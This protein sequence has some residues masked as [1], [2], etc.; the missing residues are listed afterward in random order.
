M[1]ITV[2]L[3]QFR[4]LVVAAL[5]AFVGTGCDQ[6]SAQ[7]ARSEES[8][9]AQAA[10]A[11]AVKPS[12]AVQQVAPSEVAGE[13]ASAQASYDEDAFTLT[14]TGPELAKVG[15]VVTVTV[16]LSAK[17]GF[18]VN[19]EYP[20]KFQFAETAGVAPQKAV[21]R[22]DDAQ[23]E[24]SKVVI[25]AQVVFSKSG[26]HLVQGKLSFSVCTDDRCLIEKRDLEL[27]IT[28]S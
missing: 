13:Q 26:K 11:A 5:S 7:A 1:R 21:V 2:S 19:D 17:N 20:V 3:P 25:P 27:G 18:K 24:K 28:A 4:L 14:L 10:P 15:E 8:V 22:K 6:S 9:S 16:T 23:V 12:E